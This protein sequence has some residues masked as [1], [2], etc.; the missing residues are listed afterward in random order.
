MYFAVSISE[1]ERSLLAGFLEGEAT[2]SISEMNG[3]QSLS[4][5]MYLRQRDDEQDTMEWLL[6][7]TGL[8]RIHR[9]PARATSKPQL[10]WA[11]DTQED[12][13]ELLGMIESC[14][15]HG[16]RAAELRL[17]SE[18]VRVWT[19]LGGA[20]RRS[21]L[22]RLKTELA[23]ARRFGGGEQCASRW[24]T[25]TQFLGYISGFVC[26]EGCFGL[27]DGRPRFSVHLRQD[28]EP[29]LQLLAEETRLGNVTRYR[30]APPLNPAATWTIT[31]R[32]ELGELRD[33]L[34]EAGLPGRKL[35]EMEMWGAAV[36]EYAR[37]KRLG[38]RPRRALIERARERLAAARMYRSPER[39]QLL[40]LPGRDVQSESL[41]ALRQWSLEEDGR[42]SCTKY[43]RWRK[44]GSGQPTRNTIVRQFGSWNQALAAAGLG[45]RAARVPRPRRR[46]EE[47]RQAHRRDQRAKVV[48]A[49]QRFEREHGRR[50]RASSSSD[51]GW[52]RR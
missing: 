8:G 15:F 50:P 29:L 1:Y 37:A 18:A 21:E 36:D 49:V 27:S 38:R 45:A 5:A 52:H 9:V 35:R 24:D 40:E 17:W 32:S 31:R 20:T 3:G 25:R 10:C 42:L 2:L 30:P 34:L 26:A 23:A 11:I 41:E 22:R 19:E 43:A 4:C 28:D 16:R 12:C 51:G 6:A 44:R 33:L 39:A 46:G 13:Q 48:A 7:L 47:R 14:G